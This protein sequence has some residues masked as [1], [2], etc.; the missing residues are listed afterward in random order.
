MK[1]CLAIFLFATLAIQ[2]SEARTR[3]T[4]ASPC[5]KCS[6]PYSEASENWTQ[7][8]CSCLDEDF[9]IKVFSK[10]FQNFCCSKSCP[11]CESFTL[12]SSC[13]CYGET[14]NT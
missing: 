3:M 9:P 8:G 12:T 6:E 4:V 14:N 13:E 10:D 1:I 2:N 7:G 5:A 11:K